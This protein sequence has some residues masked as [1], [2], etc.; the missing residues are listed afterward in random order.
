MADGD[1]RS[2]EIWTPSDEFPILERERLVWHPPGAREMFE[3]SL[4]QLFRP[5]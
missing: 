1:E 5:V 2:V 4:E 3:L